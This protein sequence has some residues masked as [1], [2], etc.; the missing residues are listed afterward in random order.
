MIP[1]RGSVTGK[2]KSHSEGGR[3]VRKNKRERDRER[4]R[5]ELGQ[6][7]KRERTEWVR[8]WVCGVS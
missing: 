2:W 4:I 6:Q 7:V 5:K 3:G 1:A 8:E